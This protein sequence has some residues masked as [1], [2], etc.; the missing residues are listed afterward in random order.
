MRH[1]ILV[2][3]IAFVAENT[4]ARAGQIVSYNMAGTIV[5]A[6]GT[7]SMAVGDHVAWTLQYDPS[8]PTVSG[9]NSTG[10]FTQFQTQ[11]INVITNI[12]DQT[13]GYHFPSLP[14]SDTS[15]A[16]M[17]LSN[18]NP[19][20]YQ[21]KYTGSIF[22]YQNAGANYTNAV[23]SLTLMTG[24]LPTL[25]LA[26]FQFNN[27]PV[28]SGSGLPV[29]PGLWSPSNLFANYQTFEKNPY[30]DLYYAFDAS[31]DSIPGAI[32]GA[33]EP[34]SLTLF[35]LGAAGLAAHGIRRRLVKSN[36]PAANAAG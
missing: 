4:Q 6:T 15:S 28:V 5:Y 22:A 18:S 3:A 8:T 31:V 24:T 16:G 30:N 23:T 17:E 25:N 27:L 21:N 9:G 32:M 19:G 36:Q 11:G 33:P 1:T 14:P 13:T 2:F 20:N 29:V 7:S 10:S 12:V 35:L 34:G 26:K